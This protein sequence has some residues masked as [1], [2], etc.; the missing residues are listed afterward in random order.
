M[1]SDGLLT[2]RA[3]AERLGLPESTVRYYR[4]AFP[5]L[6][7]TVGMGRRRRYPEP[8]VEVLRRIADG[9]AAGRARG[10]VLAGLGGE[11]V[12]MEPRRAGR[13]VRRQHPDQ[14][15]N[16]DLLA[17]ILDGEREQR[18]ALWQIA[19]EI[20][21][22]AEV[23]ESQDRVLTAI[24]G[25]LGAHPSARAAIP[26]TTT[27]A[28][29]AATQDADAGAAAPGLDD[30]ERLRA[31]LERERELVERLRVAKL[32]IERRAADAEAALAERSGPRLSVFRRL[33]GE[34]GA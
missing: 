21:R 1:S 9:Y 31:E 18:G 20:V 33:L 2:L 34:R 5:D 4:D 29:A 15:S 14:V 30:I 22:L 11:A 27:A 12:P 25:N 7:P 3:I 10:A 32:E 8:A 16:V 23:I 26:A 24:A 6:V 19:R 13:V 17:A 28:P